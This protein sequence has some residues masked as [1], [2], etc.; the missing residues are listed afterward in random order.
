MKCLVFLGDVTEGSVRGLL[1]KVPRVESSTSLLIHSGGGYV[2]FFPDLFP[3]LSSLRLTTIASDVRSAANNLYLLG[4][5]RLAFADSIFSFHETSMS[6][7]ESVWTM[8]ARYYG[9]FVPMNELPGTDIG[10]FEALNRYRLDLQ[11]QITRFVSHHSG[12]PGST[13]DNLMRSCAQLS[14]GEAREYGLVHTIVNNDA[15]DS[16]DLVF[17]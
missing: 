7:R 4:Q 1:S 16:L 14:S 2:D 8:L 3:Q 9:I 5:N 6:I 11:D 12:V 15:I 10:K 13:L 17:C